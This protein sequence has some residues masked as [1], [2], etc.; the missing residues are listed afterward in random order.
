ML[1]VVE[2][3]VVVERIDRGKLKCLEKNLYQCLNVSILNQ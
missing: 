3:G 2:Y 1:L